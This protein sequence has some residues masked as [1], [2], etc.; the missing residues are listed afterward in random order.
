VEAR[1]PQSRVVSLHKRLDRAVFAANGWNP[2]LSDEEILEKLL[3][4]NLERRSRSEN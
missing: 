1:D 3:A 2:N 4:L